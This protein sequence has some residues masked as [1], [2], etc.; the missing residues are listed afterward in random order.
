MGRSDWEYVAFTGEPGIIFIRDLNLGRMSVTNDAE[1]VV[2]EI[3][4]AFPGKRVVYRDT[5]GMW[6]ELVHDKGVFKRFASYDGS[7]PD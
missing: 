4:L 6:D 5:D 1:A 3:N 7:H 2:M